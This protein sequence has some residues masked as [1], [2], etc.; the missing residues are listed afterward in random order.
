MYMYVFIPDQ[1]TDVQVIHVF[2]VEYDQQKRDLLLKEHA[3]CQ[4]V[5]S[6]VEVF[7]TGRGW[8]YRCGREHDLNREVAPIDLFFCG[9]SCKDLSKL[10]PGRIEMVGCY[11]RETTDQEEPFAGSSSKTYT[12]G[13]R[14]VAEDF[15]PAVLFYENVRGAVEKSRDAKGRVQPSPIEAR[16]N[17]RMGICERKPGLQTYICI[18]NHTRKKIYIYIYVNIRTYVYVQVHIRT[19]THT[20]LHVR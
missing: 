20:C 14:K 12:L 5:F 16:T 10:N 4:H 6:D 17:P 9:P 18:Y 1:G 19:C 8:C 15:A 13:V 11:D 7:A 3:S 2:S